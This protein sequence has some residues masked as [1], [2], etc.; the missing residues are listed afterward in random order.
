LIWSQWRTDIFGDRVSGGI[1]SRLSRLQQ[2]AGV[3]EAIDDRE[4]IV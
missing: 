3:L 1:P 4:A 2:R